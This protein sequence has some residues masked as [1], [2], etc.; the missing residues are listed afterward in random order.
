MEPADAD[1][2]LLGK[3]PAKAHAAKVAAYLQSSLPAAISATIY[4]EGQKT[5]LLEDNDEA[6]PFRYVL[7][8]MR[9]P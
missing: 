7:Q 5:R 4:L 6:Q 8:T 3:Y 2:V 9:Y 1:S